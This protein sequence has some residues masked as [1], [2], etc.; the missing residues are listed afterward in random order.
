MLELPRNRSLPT[1]KCGLHFVKKKKK[2]ANSVVYKSAQHFEPG[3]I[4]PQFI[5]F[6]DLDVP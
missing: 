5:G 1:G 3:D 6:L 4:S 2:L